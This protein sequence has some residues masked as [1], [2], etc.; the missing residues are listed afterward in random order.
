MFIHGGKPYL[1]QGSIMARKVCWP[2]EHN[3]GESTRRSHELTRILLLLTAATAQQR[4][5]LVL[6]H[7][8]WKLQD[9]LLVK[10]NFA[11]ESLDFKLQ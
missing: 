9:S 7:G 5:Q 2:T 8:V 10:E 6:I 1:A 3:K 4:G 11:L